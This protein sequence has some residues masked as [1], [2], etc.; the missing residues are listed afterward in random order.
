MRSRPL[1]FQSRVHQETRC[2]LEI[3]DN[4]K[5]LI[6]ELGHAINE[7]L[8]E[9]EAISEVMARIRASGYDLFLILEVTVGFNRK[10]ESDVIHRQKFAPD[11]H[12]NST[13]EL[14]SDDA[15]FLRGLKIAVDG[16]EEER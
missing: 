10:G 15:R 9:S 12:R 2:E 8:S 13:F 6:N 3:D 4:F 1:K 16:D 7:S 14:T 11:E 5:R